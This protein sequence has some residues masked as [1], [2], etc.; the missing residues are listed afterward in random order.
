MSDQAVR[1]RYD[2]DVPPDAEHPAGFRAGMVF[3]APSPEAAKKHHPRCRI[4]SYADGREYKGRQPFELAEEAD[5][6]AAGEEGTETSPEDGE[7]T[8]TDGPSGPRRRTTG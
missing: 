5:A 3:E 2:R 7:G 4:L 1:I 8:K 6:E